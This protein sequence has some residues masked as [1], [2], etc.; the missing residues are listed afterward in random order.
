MSSVIGDLSLHFSEEQGMLLDVARGFVR[1]RAPIDVVR[2]QLETDTGFD[3][4]IWREMVDLGWTGIALP[5]SVGGS[6]LGLGAAV[7]VIE[8]LGHGLLGTP[9]ISTTLAGQVLMRAGGASAEP[10]LTRIAEG[11]AATVAWLEGADW[12][13]DNMATTLDDGGLLR[14]KKLMVSDAGSASLF[15]VLCRRGDEPAI[16]VVDRSD[17]ASTAFQSR[18]LIDLTKRSADVDFSGVRPAALLVGGTVTEAITD[19]RLL[20]ALLSAAEA[21]GS[22]ARC[23]ESIVDYLKTRKQ[24]GKLIG[25]YQ[26]LKHPAVDIYCGVENARSFVYHAASLIDDNALSKDA[27]IACRMAKVEASEVMSFAGDRSVQFM[28]GYGFTWDADSTLFIR[29]AQ[30]SR[31]VFGD[32]I[33]HRKKLAALLL[34]N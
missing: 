10:L 32:A 17:I 12:G 6:G 30:W 34:D 24:F 1:D 9:L 18:T 5:E 11:E 27:E 16:A 28:G 20:G 15:L 13:A 4:A 23:L 8:A 25:S 22:A 7:P 19:Y 3:P 33:H 29:R 2:A 14:G 26:A 21:T 31:Q